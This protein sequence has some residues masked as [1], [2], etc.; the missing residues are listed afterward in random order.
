MPILDIE[1]VGTEPTKNIA[2]RIAD[3]VGPVLNSSNGQTWVK[4]K[5]IPEGQYAENNSQIKFGPVFVSVL[6]RVL[7]EIIERERLAK[8]LC[9][10]IANVVQLS[11][12]SVHILFLPE[13]A[14]RIAFGGKLVK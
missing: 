7:P 10:A 8:K 3:A 1:L 2:Q 13:G 5:T 9:E 12:E 14:G 11:P 6:L 4:V